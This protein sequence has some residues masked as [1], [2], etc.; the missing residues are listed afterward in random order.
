MNIVFQVDTAMTIYLS[1]L[2]AGGV[3]MML[4][5]ILNRKQNVW[6]GWRLQVFLVALSFFFSG[7]LNMFLHAFG[8]W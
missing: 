3:G 4:G 5:I 2:L 7:T 8:I 6:K 1:L